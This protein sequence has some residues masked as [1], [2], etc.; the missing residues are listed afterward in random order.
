MIRA[1]R[2]GLRGTARERIQCAR[3]GRPESPPVVRL[4]NGAARVSS[5]SATGV[6]RVG[7]V[8]AGQIARTR[9]IPGFR[10]IPGVEIVAVCNMHRES[11]ARA[12]REFDIP[13]IHGDWEHLVEDDQVDAVLIG[14]WPYLHCPITLA[15]LDAG[16]HVLTQARM[17]MN[18]REA[19]RMLDRSRECPRLTAMVVPSPYGL[20]GDAAMKRLIA[21]GFLGDLREI[22]VSALSHNLADRKAPLHWRQMAKYSGFNMLNLGILHETV[23]RWTPYVEQV[24]ARTAKHIGSRLDPESGKSA[25]VGTP[26]SVHV[27]TRQVGGSLGVY[28]LS[29]ATWHGGATTIVLYG[30]KGT[31]AYDVDRDEISGGRAGDPALAPM[32]I[33]DELRGEWQVEREF[34]GAIRGEREVALTSFLEGARYMQ[35][36]EAVARSARHHMPVALP[37]AE[38]SNPSL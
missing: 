13:R 33:P 3:N 14:T 22:H 35:F 12:A 29:G 2:R 7:I 36:T 1:N 37:L 11:S 16:K 30:S 34:I 23:A 24:A 28:R 17:A 18:A 38:F 15:A 32:P 31:L 4:K 25:R 19:Q 9:H 6:I 21:D 5:S 20:A 10:S 26:D 27:L 8:G